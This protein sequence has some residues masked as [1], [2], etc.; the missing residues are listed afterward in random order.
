MVAQCMVRV[1]LTKTPR[2][3][4]GEFFFFFYNLLLACLD[5]N[6]LQPGILTFEA[7]S[8]QYVRVFSSRGL[9][10]IDG[11]ILIKEN[12]STLKEACS[13]CSETTSTNMFQIL[14]K[15]VPTV[16]CAS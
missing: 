2:E 11:K 4:L 13:T 9:C 1:I 5:L 3:V 8:F 14:I 10:V 7:Q 12:S 16:L 15:S 6:L